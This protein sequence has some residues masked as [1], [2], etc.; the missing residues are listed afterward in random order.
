MVHYSFVQNTKFFFTDFHKGTVNIIFHLISG[1]ALVYG[2]VNK[3]LLL[4]I[5]GLA[6]FDEMGHIYNYFIAHKKDPLYNPVRMVPYQM[7]FIGP[8][9]ILLFK[10]FGLI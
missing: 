5:L 9:A 3:D 6:V 4:A 2:L 10:L 8:P 1:V 7:L